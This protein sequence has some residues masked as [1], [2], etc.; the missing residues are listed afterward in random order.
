MSDK[1]SKSGPGEDEFSTFFDFEKNFQMRFFILGPKSEIGP[2]RTKL[3][4]FWMTLQSSIFRPGVWKKK[5]VKVGRKFK[6]RTPK[7]R[8]FSK[9]DKNSRARFF[10]FGPQGPILDKNFPVLVDH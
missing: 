5:F 6:N 2:F 4:G 8:N 10:I 9:T 1:S 7:G 3:F